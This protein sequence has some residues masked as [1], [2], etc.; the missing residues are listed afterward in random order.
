MKVNATSFQKRTISDEGLEYLKER[1]RYRNL[2]SSE[3]L[4]LKLCLVKRIFF[5]KKIVELIIF[6]NIE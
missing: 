1:V 6:K 4:S 3:Y 5:I 2:H